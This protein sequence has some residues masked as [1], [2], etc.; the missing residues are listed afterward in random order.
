M[1]FRTLGSRLCCIYY[2]CCHKL[3]VLYL[4]LALNYFLDD[5]FDRNINE[6]DVRETPRWEMSEEEPDVENE[7]ALNHVPVN[8]QVK[9]VR[10]Q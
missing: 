5:I 3:H 9:H 1:S 8:K 2:W 4:Q 7:Q 6:I 10:L